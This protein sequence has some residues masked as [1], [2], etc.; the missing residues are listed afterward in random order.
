MCVCV[1]QQDLDDVECAYGQRSTLGCWCMCLGLGLMLAGVVVGGAC[2]YHTYVTQV[3]SP[4]VVLLLLT[5]AETATGCK[6]I[7]DKKMPI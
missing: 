7:E 6:L 5:A 1:C 3:R 4:T 2:L